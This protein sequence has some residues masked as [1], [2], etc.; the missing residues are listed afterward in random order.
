M[1]FKA[2]IIIPANTTEA[3]AIIAMLPIARGV[4]TK[5]MVRPRPGHASLAHLVIL[6]HE[7]QMAPSSGSMNL[8]GDTFPI[9]WEEYYEITQPPYELKLKGWNEDDTYPHRFD[10]FLA[11]LPRKAIISIAVVD[12]IKNLFSI[13]SPQRIAIPSWLGGKKG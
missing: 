9:D 12:A 11:I 7:W 4:I 3:N 1:L 10:V 8:H 5:F 2:S 6:H 13:I